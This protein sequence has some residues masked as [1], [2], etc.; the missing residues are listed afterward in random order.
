MHNTVEKCA[1]SHIK[2]CYTIGVSPFS[3]SV[4]YIYTGS[5]AAMIVLV[6][7]LF[8][9]GKYLARTLPACLRDRQAVS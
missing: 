7:F 9:S 2:H 8:R 3:Q 5:G 1:I 6:A 4:H